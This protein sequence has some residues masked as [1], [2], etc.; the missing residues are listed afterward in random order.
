MYKICINTMREAETARPSQKRRSKTKKLQIYPSTNTLRQTYQYLSATTLQHTIS[1]KQM[2]QNIKVHQ[3]EAP[4]SILPLGITHLKTLCHHSLC[5]LLTLYHAGND[6]GNCWSPP[7]TI[8]HIKIRF[9]YKMKNDTPFMTEPC[10]SIHLT[11]GCKT[12]TANGVNY[13]SSL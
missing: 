11:H 2:C 3:L 12:I 9:S 6:F 10:K 1:R 4:I 8:A 7:L 5:F 13:I